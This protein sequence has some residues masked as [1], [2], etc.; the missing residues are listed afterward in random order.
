MRPPNDHVIP[1]PGTGWSVYRDALVRSAGFPVD[2]LDQLSSPGL[3][4][5]A[6]SFLDG[7][8]DFA[9]EL[10]AADLAA[11]EA[12]TAIASGDRFRQA[13]RWQN[14][15]VATTIEGS[16]RPGRTAR[17]NYRERR[18]DEIVAKYW[19]RYCGKNDSIGFFG[20]M[21]W[22]TLAEDGPAVALR[23]G[24]AAERA[25][26]VHFE[27]WALTA[28]ADALAADPRLR[29]W[30]PVRLLPHLTL[31][32]REIIAP[33]LPP[34]PVTA[35]AAALI[36]AGQ[37]SR[38]ARVIAD[39]LV[40][41]GVFHRLDDVYA[42][43]GELAQG[44]LVRLGLD[45]PIDLSAER[46]LRAYAEGIADPA[47]RAW[48]GE[49]L[50]PLWTLRDR[51]A[52]APTAETL[53]AALADLDEAF[54]EATGL[55]ARRRP[56]QTYAGRTLCHVDTSRDLDVDFGP[57]LTQKLAALEP[58]LRSVRWLTARVADVHHD[59]LA[60]LHAELAADLGT[61]DV[62]LHD[63]WFLAHGV[64]FGA[65]RPSAPVVDE[66]LRRW[67]DLLGLSAADSAARELVFAADELAKQVEAAFEDSAPGWWTARIHSPDLHL[68]AVDE[69][70][71]VRG[72]YRL[73]LGELHVAAPAFN[74][75]FFRLG[76]PDSD[77]LA[78]DLRSDLPEPCVDLLLPDEWP[79]HSARN[80][81]W[82]KGR[83][84]VQL[85]F[86]PSA[87]ADR[88]R[89]RP[90]TELVVV[91]EPDGLV[92]RAADS[93]SWP[94]LEVFAELL[95]IQT[96]DT[97]KLAGSA[98]HTPR[99]VV[100]DLVLLRE[101]WRTTVEASGLADATGDRDRV[102]AVRRWRRDLGLPER[103]FVKIGTETKPFYADL[104]GLI[105]IRQLCSAIR[106]ARATGGDDVELT[107]TEMLPTGEQAWL[108]DAHGRRYAS[109]LRL[110]LLDPLTPPHAG[111]MS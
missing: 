99:V 4:Q 80:A 17:R 73:V 95:T 11:A 77:R 104:A 24:P 110:Q 63:L 65:Q 81:N 41:A 34:R 31:R 14:P 98:A 21:C 87:G 67:R 26:A 107:I 71:L 108:P 72:D 76:H 7:G 91:A 2:G 79:R 68:I 103:I 9:E 61:P 109:E 92:A 32:D 62:P 49:R 44:G 3:A 51:A 38:P 50:S 37:S 56:G 74:T 111:R 46:V 42:Q 1:L 12:S 100:D 82:I 33:G 36:T 23:P 47:D 94:L 52:A 13:V 105:S 88:A 25:R 89:L 102:L 8:A 27:W 45:L 19:Q 43:L 20:P 75:D 59:A 84:D 85:A 78:E 39:E 93:S 86:A 48:A 28:L 6:D 70:A 10:A 69:E 18:R 15:D 55:P 96:F 97:W 35:A 60:A 53:A 101:T 64:V 106:G 30:F 83:A 54:T 40:A 22:S 90:V 16:L 5:A 29:W 57:P 66:F 58:L